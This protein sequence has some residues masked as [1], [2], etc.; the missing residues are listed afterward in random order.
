MYRRAPRQARFLGLWTAGWLFAL[1]LAGMLR[2]GD[3]RVQWPVLAIPVLWA[4]VALLRGRRSPEDRAERRTPADHGDPWPPADPW[5]RRPPADPDY[6]WP[7][8][9]PSDRRPPDPYPPPPAQ[10]PSDP[11]VPPTREMPWLPDIPGGRQEG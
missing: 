9:A 5:D 2:F 8:A 7:P 1:L 10:P 3:V 4:L 6:H 11:R